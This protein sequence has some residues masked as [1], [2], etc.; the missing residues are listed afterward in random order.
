MP[1]QNYENYWKL[2]NAFTNYSWYNVAMTDH[3]LKETIDF[4]DFII[5]AHNKSN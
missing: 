1:Q 3:S 2:A 5:K 4:M